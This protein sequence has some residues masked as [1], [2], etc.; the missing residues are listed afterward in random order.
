MSTIK[1][2]QREEQARQREAEKLRNRITSFWTS[3][4]PTTIEPK[5]PGQQKYWDALR[6]E[7]YDIVIGTGPAGTGKT[8]LATYYAGQ[9]LRARKVNCIIACRPTAT[10]DNEEHGYLPGDLSAKLSPYLRPVYDELKNC[11]HA[12]VLKELCDLEY[13]EITALGYM[14]GRTL[15]NAAVILDEGQNATYEQLRMLVTR[16]GENSRLFI[17]GSPEQLNLPKQKTSGL[18]ELLRRIG[19]HHRVS[20]IKLHNEDIVRSDMLQDLLPL[21]Y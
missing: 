6:N 12:S 14:Q 21:L 18:P 3:P 10:V 16:I 8:A 13:I 15:K 17:N 7:R 20:H 9:L 1:K 5:T 11:F 19:Y 2:Q 4:L